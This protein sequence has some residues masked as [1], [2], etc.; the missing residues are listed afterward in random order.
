[1]R[2]SPTGNVAHRVLLAT[3]AYP[4]LLRAIRRYVAPVYDYA[5]MTEPLSPAQR[6]SIGWK[7]R[8][9]VGD[10]A[11]QFH[12][13]RQTSD[14]RILWGGYDAVYRYG[15]HVRPELDDDE[16]TFAMLS[17]HFFTTFPQLEGVR[18]SHRWGGAF[19]SCSR[20]SVF[21]GT[22]HSGRVAYAVMQGSGRLDALRRARRA[23]PA[24]RPRDRGDPAAIPSTRSRAVPPEPLR[25]G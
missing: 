11:N 5:L 1:V 10:M 24:R 19:D 25:S 4:P 20:F 14:W 9:G 3:S 6:E 13:Y 16:G 18:F 21:F 2:V 15:G 17:Q 12:Y 22:A 23:R 7:R 8:Q